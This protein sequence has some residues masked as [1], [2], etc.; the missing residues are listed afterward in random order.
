MDT[1]TL[2]AGVLDGNAEKIATVSPPAVLGEFA[3]MVKGVPF[4]RSEAGRLLDEVGWTRQ[5]DG[6]RTKDGKP[7]EVTIVYSRVDLSTIEYV[8]AQLRAVGIDGKIQQLDPGAYKA[9]TEAGNYDLNISK[10]NQNDANPAF[11]MALLFY[12]ESISKS[13]K[14][15]APGAGSTF[16]NL[17]AETLSAKDETTLRRTAAEAMHE[18]VDVEVAGIP[19]AGGYRIFAMNDTVRGVQIHPSGTNQRWATVFKAK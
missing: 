18:L 4:D 16:D 7:L 1:Q 8:Q 11:I 2:V 10:P 17:I 6:I 13:A 14:T 15:I 9:A 5:G 3:D 19:L 12:S